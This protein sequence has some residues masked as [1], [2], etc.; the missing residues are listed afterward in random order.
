[1]MI[2]GNTCISDDIKEQYFVCD[3]NKCKGAC[4]EEGDAGA[5]LEK[6][7]LAIIDEVYS[8]V[9]PYLPEKSIKTIE[10]KGLYEVD[11]EGDY[12]TTTVGTRECVFAIKENGILQCAFEKAYNDGVIGF[13]KPISCHLYPIRVSKTN[14]FEL[15]NYHQWQIC[16]DACV[17]G[18][19]AKIPLY[20]F[21]KDPLI[22]K[23]GSK[24]YTQLVES[25]EN[26]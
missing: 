16:S 19:R 9:L 2:I 20:K 24:W 11:S 23:F 1:M 14:I 13:K 10:Q 18:K 15:V 6:E 3:L 4:C 17:N 21:L 7:E 12:C 22:R 25:I 26:A 8:R 5:P